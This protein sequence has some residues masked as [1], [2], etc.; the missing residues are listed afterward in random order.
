MTKSYIEA[1]IEDINSS[2]KKCG[3]NVPAR[4]AL[5]SATWIALERQLVL[6][7]PHVFVQWKSALRRDFFVKTMNDF[8]KEKMNSIIEKRRD[9]IGHIKINWNGHQSSEMVQSIAEYGCTIIEIFI[10]NG[11]IKEEALDTCL[12]VL[13]AIIEQHLHS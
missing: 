10:E 9:N 11:F 1:V 13:K 6:N 8:E 7:E 3:R 12:D 2:A 4:I 5:A